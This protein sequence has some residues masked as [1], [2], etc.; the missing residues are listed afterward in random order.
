MSRRGAGR[1]G[2]SPQLA[3]L[4]LGTGAREPSA[5]RGLAA[6]LLI[7]GGEHILVDCGEGTQ[8]QMMRS[9]AGLGGLSTILITHLHGDH[10]L[11]LPGLLAT[12]SD[13]RE[14]PLLLAGPTGTRELIDSF[15]P[16][17][18]RLRFDLEVLEVAPGREIA[19]EGYRLA[20]LPARHSGASLGWA[21]IE[22]DRRGHLDPE[23]AHSQGVPDGPALGRLAA[24]HDVEVGGRTVT[25]ASVVGP[26]EP[27]RR[28]VLS[29]DTRP[30]GALAHA[31]ESADLLVHE[32]T[33]LSRDAERARATGHTTAA[34]A[35]QVAAA[36]GVRALALTHRSRRYTTDEIL[37]E[38]RRYFPGVFA[39]EDFD[40]IE[41]PLPEH[42]RPRLVS[43][44]GAREERSGEAEE[45]AELHRD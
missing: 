40:Q 6:D 45:P 29:G 31:S 34:E 43:G 39:P 30:T 42:G 11:G 24:G 21:L 41:V 4:F 9:T 26:M 27:G 15:R 23:K 22:D 36:A 37:E 44:A 20:A 1:P 14:H 28:I 25:S 7:R 12:F 17:F 2:Q 33:F 3:V 13:V 16:H 35:A 10:V 32:A 18:G 19:R 8:R 38:A 5:E